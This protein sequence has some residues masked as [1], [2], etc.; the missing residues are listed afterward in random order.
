[1]VRVQ[2]CVNLDSNSKL[3]IDQTRVRSWEVQSG[4]SILGCPLFSCTIFYLLS[5]GYGASASEVSD[6]EREGNLSA[7][8]H[9]SRERFL[10]TTP[11]TCSGR[12]GRYKTSRTDSGSVR[13]E[14]QVSVVRLLALRRAMEDVQSAGISEFRNK[15]SSCTYDCPNRDRYLII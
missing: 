7:L 2:L 10:G 9:W 8:A 12:R 4:I 11:K 1:M 15:L 6:E 3:P 5:K 13:H 14:Q